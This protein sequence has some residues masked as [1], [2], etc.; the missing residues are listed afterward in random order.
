MIESGDMKK[1][2]FLM[3]SM[4][5]FDVSLF[6]IDNNGT[7]S[8]EDFIKQWEQLEQRKLKARTKTTEMKVK[9]ADMQ[10]ELETT[11]QLKKT[12][13]ELG[14]QIGIKD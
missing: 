12:V 3:F 8:D 9:T 11:K 5:I 1:I 13:D 7:I 2:S 4:I 10:K 6:G 14:K